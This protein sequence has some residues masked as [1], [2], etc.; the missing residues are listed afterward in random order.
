MASSLF[1]LA[2]QLS[3][4]W[5]YWIRKLHGDKRLVSWAA[6]PAPIFLH[7]RSLLWPRATLCFLTLPTRVTASRQLVHSEQPGSWLYDVDIGRSP[8]R[9]ATHRAFRHHKSLSPRPEIPPS[10]A[11]PAPHPKCTSSAPLAP[12][13][14]RPRPLPRFIPLVLTLPQL[15]SAPIVFHSCRRSLSLL[16]SPRVLLHPCVEP[17]HPWLAWLNIN[18]NAPQAGRSPGQSVCGRLPGCNLQ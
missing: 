16:C 14:A 7:A 9:K 5:H 13:H 17:A 2:S 12:I 3:T 15:P 1:R 10:L 4:P 18:T 8:D 11:H 6:R